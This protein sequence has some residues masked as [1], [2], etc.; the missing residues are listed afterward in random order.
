MASGVSRLAIVERPVDEVTV[1][2]FTGEILLDDGDLALRKK[3][4]ELMEKGQVK[5]V[6]DLAG[7]TYIDSSGIGMLVAKVGTLRQKG[8]DIK[9]MR[10]T[11]RTQTLLATLKLVMV[12]ETFE[13]E[14]AAVRSFSWR[15]RAGDAGNR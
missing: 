12:F 3:I 8:G 13:D 1:L 14:A 9:L 4:H 15:G 6:A 7:V 2:V 10:L 5:I 11:R